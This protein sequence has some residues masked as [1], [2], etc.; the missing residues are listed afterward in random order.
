MPV[1]NVERPAFMAEE[2]LNI[3][4]D[5]VGRFFEEHAPPEA[6]ARW[7]D[8]GVVDRELWNRAGEAGLLGLSI[9]EEYG[10]AGGD[11]RHEVILIEQLIAKAVDGFGISLHNAIVALT[12]TTGPRTN[13]AAAAED[14]HRR[15]RHRHRHDRAGRGLDLQ[16]VRRRRS[17]TATSMSS[18]ARRPSTPTATANLIVVV[19]K[20]DRPA[21][22]AAPADRGRDRRAD[23]FER[24]RN[25]HSSACRR[26]HL[27]LFFTTC[28]CPPPT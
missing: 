27:R 5:A 10:G 28:S 24:G 17:S 16:G 2:E 1:L 25:L 22:P 26:G 4:E 20:T 23:G 13:A 15:I 18:T 3:F 12:C 9:P 7:R 21:A 11:Y 6:T 14:L 19:A 8:E